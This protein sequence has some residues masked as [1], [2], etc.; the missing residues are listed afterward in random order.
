MTVADE[1]I[2]RTFEQ[3]TTTPVNTFGTRVWNAPK[4]YRFLTQW[5]NLAYAEGYP[6]HHL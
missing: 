4:G 3:L 6:K 2:K 5:S 1:L